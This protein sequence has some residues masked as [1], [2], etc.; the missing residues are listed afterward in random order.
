MRVTALAALVALLS[1]CGGGGDGNVAAPPATP[2]PARGDTVSVER[3]ATL[4]R[5]DIDGRVDDV[6][7]LKQ[8]IGGSARCDVRI[9]RVVYETV[10]PDG[11]LVHASA[12]LL[13]PSGCEAPHP[14]L[15]YLR[16]TEAQRS[17]TTADPRNTE[18]VLNA[19]FFAAQG[20]AV[21]M[22]DYLGYAGSTLDWH[23]YLQVE[24]TAA[25]A[26]DALRAARRTLAAAAVPLSDRLFV[27]GYSQ[28]GHAAMATVKVIERDHADEFHITASAPSSGPYALSRMVLE[29]LDS[30]T[31]GAPVFAPMLLVGLQKAWGDLY[32]RAQDAF[33]MPWASSIETLLPGDTGF[34]A[35]VEQGRLPSAL[36]GPGGLLTGGFVAGY[37]SDAAFP[38]RRRVAQNDLLGWTPSSPMLLCGGHQDPVVP[39]VNTTDAKDDFVARGATDVRALDVEGEPEFK[40]LVE[41]LFLAG[42]TIEDYHA[43]IVPPLCASIVKRRFFDRLR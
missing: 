11:R 18:T 1:A 42:A 32:V 28:G 26:I 22:P 15:A 41:L 38:A 27:W 25:T 23:P 29:N 33:Q 6:I 13:T 39:F 16:G 3:V 20:Y 24:T 12:G 10:A 14:L 34:G 19:A 9:D 35:L 7:G 2:P 31:L 37:R 36:T 8:L 30:P 5:G 17:A 4:T 21:V 43:G 40:L